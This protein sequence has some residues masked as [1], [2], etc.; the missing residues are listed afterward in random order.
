MTQV[1]YSAKVSLVVVDWLTRK[2]D[3]SQQ[4]GRFTGIVTNE[5]R[6]ITVFSNSAR[7]YFVVFDARNSEHRATCSSHWCDLLNSDIL[8]PS[9]LAVRS[10][11]F[12]AAVSAAVVLIT[13]VFLVELLRVDFMHADTSCV[14][15]WG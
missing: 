4:Q 2:N 14:L 13:I 1:V 11:L 3:Y 7:G 12:D 5:L 6:V 9:P 10:T 15:R 8:E